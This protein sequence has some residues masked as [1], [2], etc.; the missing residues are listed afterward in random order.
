MTGD[1]SSP[2]SGRSLTGA[3]VVELLE[4]RPRD[5][6]LALQARLALLQHAGDGRGGHMT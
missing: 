2:E 3:E 6:T 5:Q 1:T 4:Q